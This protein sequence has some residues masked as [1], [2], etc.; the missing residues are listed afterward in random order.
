MYS[1]NSFP[2]GSYIESVEV[3]KLFGTVDITL[4]AVASDRDPRV[5]MLYGENGT[6][7]STLLK[8]VRDMLSSDDNKGYRSSLAHTAFSSVSIGLSDGLEVKAV[9]KRGEHY[10]PF[11]WGV[12]PPKQP[13]I[14]MLMQTDSD[15]KIR[16]NDWSDD[17]NLRYK[18]ILEC[19]RS[20]VGQV[21]HLDDNRAVIDKQTRERLVGRNHPVLASRIGSRV[22]WDSP[23]GDPVEEAL[24]ELVQYVRR[25]A[26][27][28]ANRGAVDAQSI[29]ANLISRMRPAAQA[30]DHRNIDVERKRLIVELDDL[31]SKNVHFASH[32]LVS[33][34]ENSGIRRAI[35][36]ADYTIFSSVRE[37]VNAYIESFNV[38]FKAISDLHESVDSWVKSINHFFQNKYLKFKV[39]DDITLHASSGGVLYPYMLSSGERQLLLILSRSFLR[40]WAPGLMIIDEPELS[41][42]VNWQRDLTSTMLRSFSGSPV[43]LVISTHSIEIASQNMGSVRRIRELAVIG[44]S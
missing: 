39:G 12:S 36:E 6:G 40:R 4:E 5:F 17:Q 43:Q 30:F 44:Q 16:A 1:E 23:S 19:L 41:L 15:G 7:K 25:E 35:Y 18:G 21:E 31:E 27:F 32:G 29:Y 33:P 9:R 37:V 20:R 10:G 42:N 34:V 3:R 26:F 22:S 8:I 28:R 13:G 24:G 14:K 11:D 2:P 38:R